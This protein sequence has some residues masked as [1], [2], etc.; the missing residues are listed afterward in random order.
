MNILDNSFTQPDSD[1][2][3][4]NEKVKIEQLKFSDDLT[5]TTITLH[6]MQEY[7]F[8]TRSAIIS[9]CVGSGTISNNQETLS[10]NLFNKVTVSRGEQ[11]T[12][13][14]NQTIPLILNVVSAN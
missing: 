14:N 3:V 13:T 1:V 2:I 9:V 6:A 10:L 11:I 8:K 4:D 5:T 12:I 7:S